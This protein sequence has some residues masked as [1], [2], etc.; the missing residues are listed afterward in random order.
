MNFFALTQ[1]A[2]VLVVA[3]VL[4]PS[5]IQGQKCLKKPYIHA[6]CERDLNN[7]LVQVYPAR[8]LYDYHCEGDVRKCCKEEML[9]PA[10]DKTAFEKLCNND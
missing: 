2:L 10:V 4:Q 5:S 3:I 1:L 7:N 9:E 8:A 6:L